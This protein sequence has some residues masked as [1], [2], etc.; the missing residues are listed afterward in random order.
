[1]ASWGAPRRFKARFMR[2]KV[3]KKRLTGD[4]SGAI[5]DFNVALQLEPKNAFALRSRGDAKRR[6]RDFAGAMA[7]LDLALQLKPKNAFA[8]S[9]RGEVIKG[10][11][12]GKAREQLRWAVVGAGPVGLAL[13]LSLAESMQEPGLATTVP[14]IDVYES[15]WIEWSPAEA[16]WHRASVFASNFG[17]FR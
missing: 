6:L 17:H 15:R 10:L 11:L 12:P 13:T 8:L 3:K 7:D 2:K 4:F 9:R 1:M 14:G 5:A 16:K